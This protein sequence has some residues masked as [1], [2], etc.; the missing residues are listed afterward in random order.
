MNTAL[1]HHLINSVI[2]TRYYCDY[3]RCHIPICFTIFGDHTVF[4]S[5]QRSLLLLTTLSR[6]SPNVSPL[7]GNDRSLLS[8][9][10][11]RG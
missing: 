1:P 4:V 11:W 2:P 6:V 10:H 5:L 9:F 3:I 8:P 7:S